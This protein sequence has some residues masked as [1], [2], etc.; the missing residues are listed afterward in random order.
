MQQ[1]INIL[2][3]IKSIKI[4]P[5]EYLLPLLEVV[6][7]AIQSIEDKTD[8]EK[9]QISIKAIRSPLQTI[10]FEDELPYNPIIG[11]EVYDNGVGFIQSRFSAFGDAFTD[12]NAKK[13]CKGI[14]RYT[15][16]ACFGSMEVNST[17]FENGKWYNR[18]FR[19]DNAKENNGNIKET[20]TQILKT[21]I[22]LNNYKKEF[23]SYI[24]KNKI[25]LID[26][27]ENIIQHCLLYFIED[28]MPAIK[29]YDEGT[30][31]NPIF[32]ND[33]Y[34]NV[35]K[36]DREP[37]QLKIDNI[38]S[39]FNLNY[40]KNYS[41]KAH[42]FH[43]CANKREVGKKTNMSNFIPSFVQS[44]IDE[45][46]KKYYLS[47][48]VT[49]DFLDEKANNQ[50]NEFS[51]PL[52][53]EQKTDFDEICLS[54][55]FDNLSDNV[56]QTYSNFIETADKE[57][58]ERIRNYIL[59]GKTPRLAYKHLLNVSNIFDDIY[60]NISD[61][62]LE[63][64]LAKKVFQL[65]QKRTKAFN[66]AFNKK[67]YDKEEFG[68]ILTEVL[69][70]EAAFSQDKLADLMVRR[71]SVIKL[72]KQYLEW[73]SEEN[74][75]LE[76]DLHN[77]IFTMGA[78]TD[79][80]PI[81]Y[82]NLWLLDER[83]TFYRRTNSDKQLRTNKDF[84]V[85]SQKEPDL[86]IYDF[87]WAYSDNPNNVNSLVL[88]EF[89]RPGRDMNTTKDKKLDSQVEGYFEK[90]MESKATNE[91]GRI[92]N[93]QDN[94]AKFGYVICELHKELEEYNIKY[95]Y[96]K[97][98]PYGTLYKINPELNMYIEVMSYQTMVDFAEKRHDAFFQA[99]GIH[100]L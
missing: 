38:D 49:G 41:N 39:I 25:E 27:A 84:D 71:K 21:K 73:R 52:K 35:I 79:T 47:I 7:N 91:K 28:A 85:N 78:E 61:E 68:K 93:V 50:R 63:A 13:G 94:T 40:L 8:N 33:I 16:L 62:R 67:K 10:E 3:Y 58:N 88:F 97:K 14:G 46:Q 44:L 81:D 57:K 83:L 99:L 43:L 82:H 12:F 89:K 19:F 86:L 70:E 24:T 76:E 22:S 23:I 60:A 9:G 2:N 34:R 5:D 18:A 4:N 32:L 65:E 64:E 75:M 87:P 15:V 96:F 77:I 20:D 6:V 74:Y 51:V 11:F 53:K 48:Y 98:T 95:N 45:Q 29:L 56:R 55:L 66:K 37:A 36:F 30:S 26:I 31:K 54:E 1:S 72:F 90:L 69:R 17:F 100:N 42:S 80:M 59:N 92:L